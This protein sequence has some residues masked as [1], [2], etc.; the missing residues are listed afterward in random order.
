MDFNS[1]SIGKGNNGPLLELAALKEYAEPL[2]PKIVLWL[3]YGNDL[4]DLSR[5]MKSSILRKYLNEDNYSQNLISRQEE[6]DG[7]LIN[8]IPVK[9]KSIREQEK[10]RGKE[11]IIEI[12]K[13]A[14]LRKMINLKPA[15][16]PAAPTST[17]TSIS[18]F[19]N[20]L[21]KSNQMVSQ[22]NGKIYFV[23]LPEFARYS[24]GNEDPNRDFV[25]RTATEPDIPIIDMQKEVFDMHSDPLS[26]FP[27]RM[28]E[29]HYNAEGYKLVAEAIGKRLEEDG[30][31]PT[32]SKK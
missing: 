2:K 29:S 13:L 5:D 7:V 32:K 6:I 11:K 15:I 27:S 3:Y 20:I 21:Q 24:I 14:K 10:K 1:I 31:V 18:I 28:R 4:S 8:Y 22:W 25:L 9:W 30:Y 16:I 17:S 12:L 19:R 23:Y 26:L